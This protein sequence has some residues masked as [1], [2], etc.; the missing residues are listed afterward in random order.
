MC[1]QQDFLSVHGLLPTNVFRNPS[2]DGFGAVLEVTSVLTPPL[3]NSLRIQR[4][5]LW[6]LGISC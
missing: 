2:E 4:A 6:L 3:E 5:V 1:P